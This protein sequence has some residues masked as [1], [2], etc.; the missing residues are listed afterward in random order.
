MIKFLVYVAIILTVI[1]IG[2]LARVFELASKLKGSKPHEVTDRDNKLMSRIMLIWLIALFVFVIWNL[3]KY[4]PLLLP[5]SASEHGVE[6]DALFNFNWAIIFFVFAITQAL[7][8]F[9]AYKY[10]GRK[11]NTATYLS[12]NNKIEMIWTVI[13]AIVLSIIIIKGLQQWNKITAPAD[14]DAI[15]IQLYAKQFDWT[16]RYAGKD[17]QLGA[18]NYRLITDNNALGLDSADSKGFDDII[19]R[20]EIHLPLGKEISFMINSRDVIHSAYFPHFRSQINCM[21]GMTTSIHF[22]PILT[23][24]QMREKEE[25]KR[26]MAG[27]NARRAERGDKPVEFDYLL[28]CNKICGNSHYN[29]Q[30]TVI[31]DTEEDYK[32][33]L[34][35][36]KPFFDKSSSVVVS[37]N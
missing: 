13:P 11:D 32:K 36:K 20:N 3:K 26:Q 34:N 30:M 27:I 15:V 14:K 8:F 6:M 10:Y 1:A 2:Y 31:V 23:T 24:A 33:W 16:A 4:V 18:S 17:N 37:K 9:F 29:M 7:L 25:V 12:H 28:L 19:V 5:E 21:P 22:K 35:S